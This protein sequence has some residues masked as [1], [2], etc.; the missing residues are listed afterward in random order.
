[1]RTTMLAALLLCGTAV[2]LAEEPPALRQGLWQFDRT[3]RE[4]K[5][6]RQECV[7]HRPAALA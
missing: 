3:V 2:A 6:Q 7:R 4:Q 5:L 1:M